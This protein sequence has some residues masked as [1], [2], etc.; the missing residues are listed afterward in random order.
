MYKSIRRRETIKNVVYISLI[1]LVAI[2]STYLIYN[3]FV[4]ERKIDSSSEMLEVTYR[5]NSGNKIAITKVTPLTDSVGLST[6]NYGLT[7]SNNLTEEVNYKIIVKDDIDT[8]LEDHCEEYQISKDDIR[9]SVKVGKNENK[10]YTLSELVDGVL[11]EDKIKALDKEEIS[12]R[13]WVSQ[14]STLPLGSN[15]HYHGIVDVIDYIP[16]DVVVSSE[17]GE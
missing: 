5:D 2:V 4:D 11:L 8:I 14:N 3:K 6:T 17:M 13:V 15:I 10:I 16:E 12:I 7:L 1:L 9:I